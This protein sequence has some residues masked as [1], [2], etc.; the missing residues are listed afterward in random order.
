MA[1]SANP[2]PRATRALP[3]IRGSSAPREDREGEHEAER[4]PGGDRSEHNQAEVTLPSDF[5]G[6]GGAGGGNGHG[7]H[8]DSSLDIGQ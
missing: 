8:S 2:A 6:S 7:G 5:L 3:V 4:K 1:S